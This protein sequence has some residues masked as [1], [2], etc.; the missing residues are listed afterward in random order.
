MSM[1]WE[2]G[3]TGNASSARLIAQAV[4]EVEGE[5][6]RVLEL[7][8]GFGSRPRHTPSQ[9]ARLLHVPEDK[10]PAMSRAALKKLKRSRTLRT[11]SHAL[12]RGVSEMWGALAGPDGLLFKD[13]LGEAIETRLPGEFQV[14]LRTMDQE[15][16]AWLQTH[17]FE[18]S[19][20]WYRGPHD[21]ET[22]KGAMD[23]VNGMEDEIKLPSPI[24]MACRHLAMEADLLIL[25]VKL[26]ARAAV[27]K[28]YVVP[29]SYGMREVR[30]IELHLL[31]RERHGERSV[32]AGQ[33]LEDYNAQCPND[34]MS[35][36]YCEMLLYSNPHLFLQ[37]GEMGWMCV[38]GPEGD[39]S[40]LHCGPKPALSVTAGFL[41]R[42]SVLKKHE[43][44][45]PHSLDFLR[46]ALAR[47]PLHASELVTRFKSSYGRE[48]TLKLLSALIQTSHEVVMAAPEIYTL[49]EHLED[50]AAMESALDRLMSV[51]LCRLYALGRYA[52]EPAHAYPL[53]EHLGE[54]RLCR[55]AET[56]GSRKLFASLLAVVNPREWTAPEPFKNQWSFKKSCIG[57]RFHLLSEIQQGVPVRPPNLDEVLSVALFTR[58]L[59]YTNWLRVQKIVSGKLMERRSDHHAPPLLALLVGLGVLKPCGHWQGAHFAG[60]QTDSVIQLLASHLCRRGS[61][62]WEEK[63][64]APLIERL[65]EVCA[66]P[67]KE[68]TLGWVTGEY[69]QSLIHSLTLP[70]KRRISRE[71]STLSPKG[72]AR[73]RAEELAPSTECV[74]P[75][76]LR[77]PFRS[78]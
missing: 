44:A 77:L 13:E 39:F 72:S 50:P 62:Y 51:R 37:V 4:C 25:A 56:H 64:G 67:G 60:P 10:I 16:L 63:V 46:E 47:G 32:K 43:R 2:T 19:T 27:H 70:K 73:E 23:Q 26:G 12:E 41:S 53:W 38:G 36:E 20:A 52:G 54:E 58:H 15:L 31:L 3:D 22:L 61:I 35:L 28:G 49:R 1:D 69:L 14:A 6:S 57:R 48:V 5:E 42:S 55:W 71:K 11:L 9:V 33:A 40:Y 24:Q 29:S 76:Q 74:R 30:A 78:P 66:K 17:A 59:G 21:P 8:Y 18:A 75:V 45:K 34:P 7:L 65:Q 68:E